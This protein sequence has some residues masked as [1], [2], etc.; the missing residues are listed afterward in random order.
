MPRSRS[1]ASSRAP[2]RTPEGRGAWTRPSG[3]RDGLIAGHE[4]VDARRA[5]EARRVDVLDVRLAIARHPGA[6]LDAAEHVAA[7]ALDARRA[8]VGPVLAGVGEP[9]PERLAL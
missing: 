9:L 3:P 8:L 1:A 7:P 4:I 5:P 2:R 6:A